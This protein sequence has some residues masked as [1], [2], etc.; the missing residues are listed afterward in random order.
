MNHG[1]TER[2][3]TSIILGGL[4][5]MAA[6]AALLWALGVF[7]ARGPDRPPP[8]PAETRPATRPATTRPGVEPAEFPKVRPGADERRE[9]RQRMVA[10]LLAYR[11]PAVTDARVIA[12]MRAV[13]RHRFIPARARFAAYDDRPVSIGMGQTISQPY[14]VA[15]M[16]QLAQ[17]TPG[18]RVLEV[19]AGSGYQAAILADMGCEVYTIEIFKELGESAAER[20]R[21]MHY[22]HVHVRVGDGYFGWKEHAPYDAVVVTCAATH[23]PPALIEQVK[24]GGRIIIPIGPA[25]GEQDLIVAVKEA[26]G[27]VT[28][29]SVLGVAFVPLRGGHEEIPADR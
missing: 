3:V 18:D 13:P 15:L 7:D 9:E 8:P 2:S 21:E 29:R 14:I 5:L 20:L 23:V 26:D 11:W 16:S 28:S 12:A 27:R 24:P 4:A 22:E 25:Y 19:G 6:V 17:T 1:P 10:D